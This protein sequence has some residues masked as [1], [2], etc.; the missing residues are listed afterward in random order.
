MKLPLTL[1]LSSVP[2]LELQDNSRVAFTDSEPFIAR[3][4]KTGSRILF[5]CGNVQNRVVVIDNEVQ[6]RKMGTWYQWYARSG[7][8]FGVDSIR[9]QD[10]PISPKKYTLED[11][12]EEYDADRRAAMEPEPEPDPG[13]EPEPQPESPTEP[14]TETGIDSHL[15][16]MNSFTDQQKALLADLVQEWVENRIIDEEP[17][18]WVDLP[19][20]SYMSRVFLRECAANKVHVTR[21]LGTFIVSGDLKTLKDVDRWIKTL[22]K[23]KGPDSIV[24]TM[25]Q[26]MSRE[27]PNGSTQQTAETSPPQNKEENL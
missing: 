19:V 12:Q 6:I 15:S 24:V 5:C 8:E 22:L 7:E 3:N 9:E 18:S 11:L 14:P 2:V 1:D 13:H 25:H 23:L 16:V 20:V 27:A 26:W 21:A 17:F 4:P 10:W